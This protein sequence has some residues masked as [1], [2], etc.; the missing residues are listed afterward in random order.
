[1]P[2]GAIYPQTELNGDPQAVDGIGRSVE[3]LGYGRVVCYHRTPENE[4]VAGGAALPFDAGS[5]GAL[6]RLLQGILDD[7]AAHSVWKEKARERTRERYRWDDVVD[8]Y[9]SEISLGKRKLVG[10][11]RA[12]ARQL[13]GHR[14]VLLPYCVA[15]SFFPLRGNTQPC[16][17]VVCEPRTAR[18]S[19]IF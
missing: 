13:R 7:P 10:V 2:L 15:V 12:L 18:P 4:E 9:P 11:G 3:A 8:R 16:L 6:A 19:M 14:L 17:T 1:M 5:R